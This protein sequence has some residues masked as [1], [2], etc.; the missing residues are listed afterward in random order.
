MII[1]VAFS[2]EAFKR[3]I[4]FRVADQFR[5]LVRPIND[6]EGDT[7]WID[8]LKVLE[9]AFSRVHESDVALNE[10]TDAGELSSNSSGYTF[11]ATSVAIDIPLVLYYAKTQDVANAGL[12]EPPLGEIA[13]P[14]GVIR[15]LLRSLIAG[16]GL[17]HIQMKLDVSRLNNI[18]MPDQIIDLLGNSL[19]LDSVFDLAEALGDL[20]PQDNR[21]VLNTAI[22]IDENHNI[23]IRFEFRPQNGSSILA[24]LQDWQSFTHNPAP[25]RL[26]GRDWVV[27]VEGAVIA[28]SLGRSFNTV[29]KDQDPLY[30]SS[31]MSSTFHNGTPPRVSL[32]KPGRVR[33]AC[34]GN[35]VRF[36]GIMDFS[37]S[38]PSS[39]NAITGIM[40]FDYLKNDW[41]MI[42]CYGLTILNPFSLLISGFDQGYPGAGFI[43]TPVKPVVMLGGLVLLIIGFDKSMVR[44]FISKHLATEPSVQKLPD[45]RYAFEQDFA[46]DNP[47]TQD[48]M[49]LTD[50]VGDSGRFLLRG[51][52][53]VPDLI[54]PRLKVK[55]LEGFLPWQL[56]NRCEPGRGQA[57]TS[58]VHLFVRGYRDDPSVANELRP[59]IPL[60]FG[61]LA[62]EIV[63][64]KLGV[65]QDPASEYT[66]IFLPGIPGTLQ[67][68]LTSSTLQKKHFE[69]FKVYPYSLRIRIFTNGGIREVEFKA[70][71]R[72]KDYED[73]PVKAAERIN[74]CKQLVNDKY[75]F[76][77][78]HV[79]PP[80][81]EKVG[82]LW[83]LHASGLQA[84]KMAR[85]FN[86]DTGAILD[87]ITV[88]DKGM[89]DF[90]LTIPR[91]DFASALLIA[92]DDSPFIDALEVQA[93]LQRNV[94]SE[95][96]SLEVAVRQ[97]ILFVVEDLPIRDPVEKLSIEAID[98]LV[99]I[100]ARTNG[101]DDHELILGDRYK[102]PLRLDGHLVKRVQ[103]GR[104]IGRRSLPQ[105]DK[106]GK[107]GLFRPVK[108][109]LWDGLMCLRSGRD[110]DN[111][112]YTL[113]REGPSEVIKA[114]SM[115]K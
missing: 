109:E 52:L 11:S 30:F 15:V 94:D 31:G 46:M 83:E 65:Y 42:K 89:L 12:N 84:G 79:D 86:S 108:A 62:Y 111:E 81:Y 3:L 97:A 55:D 26:G 17:P 4:R 39:G 60:R 102:V 14:Q 22:N 54:M 61:S 47:I 23:V 71:E 10:V 103:E 20:L 59:T 2:S 104:D 53:K 92:F 112:Q 50:V 98:D 28:S 69:E 43:F 90:T 82:Q 63:G 95:L 24:R 48:W 113:Y 106:R 58:S 70:P 88:D 13:I 66:Q 107:E 37:F 110:A 115:P 40:G 5:P 44:H 35:D 29:I 114:S 6:P 105:E 16:D 93:Q 45:G 73:S 101:G 68:R 80:P 74:K 85:V 33:A 100:K 9:P 67:C 64:D 7:S 99:S 27:D 1:N 25:A 36:D 49:L 75:F 76:I 8:G 57:T 34:F 77:K 78:W 96:S 87:S 19:I 18:P 72:Y 41:D 21:R 91:D 32:T 51:N 56:K 38:V